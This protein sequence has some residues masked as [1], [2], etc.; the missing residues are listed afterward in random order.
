[1][2]LDIEVVVELLVAMAVDVYLR[3]I[4]RGI[5][6]ANGGDPPFPNAVLG[7]YGQLDDRRALSDHRFGTIRRPIGLGQVPIAVAVRKRG[8]GSRDAGN[9]RTFV[10]ERH[11]YFRDAGTVHPAIAHHSH[12]ED[13]GKVEIG[14]ARAG[15]HGETGV[16]DFVT[17]AALI[18]QHVHIPIFVIHAH[19]RRAVAV[20]VG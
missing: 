2:A 20:F 1:M 14:N 17:G 15:G 8:R 4:A 3:C 6:H 9:A 19:Q 13:L 10:F 16:C 5:L 7:G 11:F 18:A 12:V